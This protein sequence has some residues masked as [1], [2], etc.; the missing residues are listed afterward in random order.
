MVPKGGKEPVGLAE[1]RTLC[2]ACGL[3]AVPISRGSGQ[4]YQGT[5]SL[6]AHRD[7]PRLALAEA[8]VAEPRGE[9]KSCKSSSASMVGNPPHAS[10]QQGT[11]GRSSIASGSGGKDG[12]ARNICGGQ[13]NP[14]GG[15]AG[16]FQSS[17]M[18]SPLGEN[19]LN[20]RSCTKFHLRPLVADTRIPICV[21]CSRTCRL[22]CSL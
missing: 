21:G 3:Q 8:G 15:S 9:D 5:R 2:G 6:R 12:A 1:S 19:N 22:R 7:P 20:L 11:H 16:Q 17:A 18:L 14:R 4:Q 13:Q 10:S